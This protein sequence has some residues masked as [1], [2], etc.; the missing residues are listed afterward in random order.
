M[1]TIQQSD[2]GLD[3][4]VAPDGDRRLLGCLPP[5]DES[6]FQKYSARFGDVAIIPREQWMEVD[7][8]IFVPFVDD[9]NGHGACVGHGAASGFD[10]SWNVMRGEKR[11]FSPWFV[12]SQVNGGRDQGAIVSDALHAMI[13]LGVPLDETVPD[14]AWH[15]SRIPAN[16]FE[17][18]TRFKVFEGY[19]LNTFDE[20]VSA[21]LRRWPVVFG[22]MLGNRFNPNPEGVIPPWDGANVGGHCLLGVGVKRIAGQ[23]YIRTL[24]S[25]GTRWGLSGYCYIPESYF[26]GQRWPLDAFAIQSPQPD[27]N[28]IADDPPAKPMEIAV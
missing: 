18:A 8:S 9:Q 16:A 17:E 3:F 1:S 7:L 20:M 4:V 28:D 14:K 19:E 2:D 21:L 27:P 5:R 26:R 11:K 23:W 25:W 13:K 10:V 15:K 24:N 12:Y 6:G 22:I